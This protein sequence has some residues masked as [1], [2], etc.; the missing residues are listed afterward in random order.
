MNTSF[1]LYGEVLEA[2]VVEPFRRYGDPDKFK[3]HIHPCDSSFADIIRQR[4]ASIRELAQQDS[5]Y[6]QH[7]Y[8]LEYMY[9]GQKYDVRNDAYAD[10]YGD[11]F[12]ESLYEPKLYGEPNTWV[13]DEEWRGKFVKVNGLIQL[14]KPDLNAFLSF[15]LVDPWSNPYETDLESNC[16]PGCGCCDWDF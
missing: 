13:C 4:V 8:D 10:K 9:D 5:E 6:I 3:L 7:Q 14:I 15:H 11:I 16:K 12:V 2:H 1:E